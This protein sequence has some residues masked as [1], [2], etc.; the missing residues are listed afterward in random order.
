MKSNSATTIGG[1]IGNIGKGNEI[2]N[3][4]NIGEIIFNGE[5]DSASV[6]I[7]GIAGIVWDVELVML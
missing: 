1:I 5:V 3:C 2:K 6:Y 4:Y 7:A